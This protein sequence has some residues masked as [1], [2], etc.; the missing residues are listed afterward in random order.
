VIQRSTP[1]S[2][3][4][5]FTPPYDKSFPQKGESKPTRRLNGLHLLMAPRVIAALTA[6]K[7]TVQEIGDISD[8]ILAE[9]ADEEA[10]HYQARAVAKRVGED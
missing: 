8:D 1:R 3:T 5:S 7:L 9:S 2:D 6:G 4:P 10:L